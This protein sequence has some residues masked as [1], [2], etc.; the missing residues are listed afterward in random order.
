MTETPDIAPE[1]PPLPD[2]PP[3]P[4]DPSPEVP[5]QPLGPPAELDEEDAPL[6]GVPEREPP[7][8]E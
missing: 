5:D 8:S 1:D 6:P 3:P 7:A 4:D 2:D